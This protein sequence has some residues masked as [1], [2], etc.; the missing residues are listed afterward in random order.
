MMVFHSVIIRVDVTWGA[1]ILKRIKRFWAKYGLNHI[2]PFQRQFTEFE[3]IFKIKYILKFNVF[4]KITFTI[5]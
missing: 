4:S 3:L 5:N 2:G 1:E